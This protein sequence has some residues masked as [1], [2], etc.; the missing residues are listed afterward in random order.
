MNETFT[1]ADDILD[2]II[3]QQAVSRKLYQLC[4]LLIARLD[5]YEDTTRYD[6]NL[7]DIISEMSCISF[8]E[9]IPKSDP[10]ALI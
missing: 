2:Q 8:E 9:S 3:R 5:K 4:S 6:K 10:T 1:P 7:I